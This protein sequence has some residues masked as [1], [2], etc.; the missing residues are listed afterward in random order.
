M[1]SSV[2]TKFKMWCE[3]KEGGVLVPT[4]VFLTILCVLY[5]PTRHT[6]N[7]KA[8]SY[9]WSGHPDTERVQQVL[10]W[11]MMRSGSQMTQ[12]VLRALPCSFLVEEPLREYRGKGRDFLMSLLK[13]ILQC[14][15]LKHPD[16]FSKWMYGIHLNEEEVRTRCLE[17]PSLC[18][19][20][21]FVDA[22]CRA[23]CVHLIR[24]V[25]IDMGVADILLQDPKLD[26]KIIHLVRDP[27]AVLDSRSR[28][29]TLSSPERVFHDDEMNVTNI[30]DRYRRDLS[31]AQDFTHFHP[32]R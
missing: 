21:A 8:Y 5:F 19:N 15:F 17:M 1:S 31:A 27:R 16:Y 20:T 22:V 13:D 11:T 26:V 24:V 6:V 12:D 10:L 7:L 18:N 9:M 2:L 28:L 4:A 30:C 23:A 25:S 32:K 29:Q 14:R 3:S